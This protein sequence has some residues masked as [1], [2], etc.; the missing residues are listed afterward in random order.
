MKSAFQLIVT[1]ELGS[2][3][4]VLTIRELVRESGDPAMLGRLLRMLCLSQR[5]PTEGSENFST[6]GNA[7]ADQEILKALAEAKEGS[8]EPL[9]SER[10]L[11]VDNGTEQLAHHL[12]SSLGDSA[13]RNIAFYRKVARMVPRAV[14]LDA[15]TRARDAQNIRKSR[16][17]LFAYLMR[18]HL[19][20]DHSSNSSC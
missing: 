18:P 4:R 12:A 14:A 17:H 2:Q 15:L 20:S 9:G 8:G 6:S 5:E 19:R 11:P 1:L 13:L 3:R 16:A 7:N 10:P